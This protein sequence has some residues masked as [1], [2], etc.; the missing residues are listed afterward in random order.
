MKRLSIWFTVRVVRER[1]SICVRAFLPFGFESGLWDLIVIIPD[2]Q[3]KQ[4]RKSV[5]INE[6]RSSVY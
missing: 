2:E 3:R 6:L 5:V 4:E 1:L